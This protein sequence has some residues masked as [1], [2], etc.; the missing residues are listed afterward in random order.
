MLRPFARGLICMV[1]D[2]EGPG[3]EFKVR[4]VIDITLITWMHMQVMQQSLLHSIC[5]HK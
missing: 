2:L 4:L 3:V 1:C 5:K